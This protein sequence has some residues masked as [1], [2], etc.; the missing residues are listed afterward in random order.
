M[1]LILRERCGVKNYNPYTP[2]VAVPITLSSLTIAQFG[3]L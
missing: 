3:S 1:K 2:R